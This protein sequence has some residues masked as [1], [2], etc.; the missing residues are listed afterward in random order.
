MINC[1]NVA[2]TIYPLI[3]LQ[4]RVGNCQFR[5]GLKLQ[6][7]ECKSTPQRNINSTHSVESD[8]FDLMFVIVLK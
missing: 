2:A 1:F 4:F 6:M 7:N 3:D 8:G 5:K